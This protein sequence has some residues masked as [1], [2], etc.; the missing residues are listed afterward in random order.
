LLF[1]F[2]LFFW[3]VF[4]SVWYCLGTVQ[5]LFCLRGSWG[6]FPGVFRVPFVVGRF[7]QVP[8]HDPPLPPIGN[9][10]FG[11]FFVGGVVDPVIRCIF[12]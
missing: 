6:W 7:F 1:G 9:V 12:S 3:F 4:C 5:L 2:G 11:L 10:V 8:M